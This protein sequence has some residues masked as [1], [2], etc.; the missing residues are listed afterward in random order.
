MPPGDGGD[1]AV[2]QAP[3]RDTGL[4]ASPVDARG[5]LEVGGWVELVQVEPQQQAAQ[6]R[7]PGIGARPGTPQAKSNVRWFGLP[8]PVAVADELPSDDE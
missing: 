6:V 1:H 3:W 5:A 7:F 4:P 8:A 2:D